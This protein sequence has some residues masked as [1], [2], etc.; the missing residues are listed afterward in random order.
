MS[1]EDE[2]LERFSGTFPLI[3]RDEE[4]VDEDGA[5]M[6]GVIVGTRTL[7]GA[8]PGTTRCLSSN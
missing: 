2:R 5:G 8:E 6:I 1:V 7:N 4:D 3:G